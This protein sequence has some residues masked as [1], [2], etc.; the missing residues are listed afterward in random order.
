MASKHQQKHKVSEIKVKFVCGSP[1][2][3]FSKFSK[4]A[5]FIRMSYAISTFHLHFDSKQKMEAVKHESRETKLYRCVTAITDK[6]K[7]HG[8]GR[9]HAET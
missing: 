7:Q 8:W 1:R 2:Q 9:L 5:R 6:L 3:F 4:V